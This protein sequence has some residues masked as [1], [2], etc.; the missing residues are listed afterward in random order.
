MLRLS[1]FH[2]DNAIKVKNIDESIP[3]TDAR[4]V[5]VDTEL[6]GL[7][8]KRD[9]IVSIGALR[10]R[11]GRIDL[12]DTFYRLVNP[13]TELTAKSV[14]IHEITPS[15]VMQKPN[16]NTVLSEFIEFCGDDVIIGHCI[17]IDLSFID[18]E[19]KRI[20]GHPLKNAVLDTFTIYEWLSRKAASHKAFSKPLRD[21]RL[22]EMARYFGVPVSGAHN[23]IMDAY[24]TA[25]LFQRFI[26]ILLEAGVRQIGHLLMAGNPSRGGDR[27]RLSSEAIN[28]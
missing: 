6:T 16:I 13:E 12:G 15:E 7:N 17:S 2:K 11:G 19:M 8:E 25:Q 20:F 26:P 23:A 4:Y 21:Y 5:V 10:M 24:I 9:S 28:F 22:Y 14:V 1:I 27:F 18:R 3:I